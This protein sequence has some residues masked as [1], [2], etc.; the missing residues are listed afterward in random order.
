M[1][2]IVLMTV[3]KLS[4]INSHDIIYFRALYLETNEILLLKIKQ[5]FCIEYNRVIFSLLN[6]RKIRGFIDTFHTIL[7]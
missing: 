3:K 1:F 7:H 6:H 4:N 2:T 5:I